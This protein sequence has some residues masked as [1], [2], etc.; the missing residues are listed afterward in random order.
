MTRRNLYSQR[1]DYEGTIVVALA[2]AVNPG[3][4]VKDPDISPFNV[5]EEIGLHR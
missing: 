5:G 2:G 1:N 3:D 4:L